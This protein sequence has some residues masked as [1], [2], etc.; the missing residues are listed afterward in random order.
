M[1]AINHLYPV[2]FLPK[3]HSGLSKKVGMICMAVKGTWH[4][5]VWQID[6]FHTEI[7]IYSYSWKEKETTYPSTWI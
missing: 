5:D 6:R 2:M 7:E 3:C 4:D 1:K